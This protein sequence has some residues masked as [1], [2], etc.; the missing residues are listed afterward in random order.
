MGRRASGEILG[1]VAISR[2]GGDAVSELRWRELTGHRPAELAGVSACSSGLACAGRASG[3]H[4]STW[5]SANPCARARPRPRG[6]RCSRDAIRLY[7]EER[8]WRLLA[9]YRGADLHIYYY[10]T[11]DRRR[12]L[13]GW[14]VSDS[15]WGRGLGRLD[16]GAELQVGCR[17]RARA[18]RRSVPDVVEMPSPTAASRCSRVSHPNGS[19]S[20]RWEALRPTSSSTAGS[21]RTRT[22]YGCGPRAV[23]VLGGPCLD[24]VRGPGR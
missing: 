20:W 23:V 11:A 22:G 3:R 24:S 12:F 8:G 16:H 13:A 9:M 2:V 10:G 6:R 5:P 18:S 17:P 4:S 19:C 7:H 1:H 15:L 14:I 21:T